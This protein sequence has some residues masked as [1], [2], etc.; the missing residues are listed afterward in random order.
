[1][2]TA[3]EIITASLRHLG[4]VA[5]GEVPT[6]GEAQ[7]GLRLLNEMLDLW[8]LENMLIVA[9]TITTFTITSGKKSYTVGPSQ[10][11]NITWPVQIEQ[12]QLRVDNFSPN[13]DLPM[14]VLNEQEYGLVRLKDQQS[15]YPQAI[16]LHTTFPTGTLFLWPVPSQQ[17]E[18]VIWHKETVAS[19]ATLDTNVTLPRGYALAL[20]YNL[21]T[22]LASDYGIDILPNSNV[23]R[24]ARET[25]AVIKR[26]NTK[27]TLGYVD[28][29]A[30]Q[31]RDYGSYNWQQDSG[32]GDR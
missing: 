15:T 30:G 31:R 13:L 2:T 23:D 10:D 28:V 14:R 6:N 1:M 26:S 8:S 27:K 3:R 4:V 17:N 9:D 11:V 29:P 24:Q 32:A 21:A 5:Q 20:R 25:R 12:A 18:M 22:F 16:F 7:D 19:F